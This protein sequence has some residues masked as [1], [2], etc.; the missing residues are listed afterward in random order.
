MN[1]TQIQKTIRTLETELKDLELQR[2]TLLEAIG[3]L[4]RLLPPEA[5]GNGNSHA[6]A[7][8]Q[9]AEASDFPGLTN[10]IL[11]I[12]GEGKGRPVPVGTIRDT[13]RQRGWLITKQGQDRSK[14]IYETLRRLSKSGR[15]HKMGKRGYVL[16]EPPGDPR[17]GDLL[18]I[19]RP[20][21]GG[22]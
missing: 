12:I 2:G 22:S 17:T 13:F 15:L 20:A 10:G 11:A 8:T 14:T 19:P 6:S 9:I 18:G 1:Q 3:S 16:P 21:G 4:R 7:Q 5:N